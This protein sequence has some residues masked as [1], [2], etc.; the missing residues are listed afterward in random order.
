MKKDLTSGPIFKSLILFSLP[1]ILGNL[2]QQVYNIAD[3]FIVG[4][5]VSA[6]A[7]AAVGSAY[8]LMTFLTSIIIGLCMGSGACFSFYYGQKDFEQ[9]K[10]NISL[11]FV[12][13]GAVTIVIN[14]VVFIFIDGILRLLQVPP[15]LYEMMRA[16]VF[17][18]FFGLFFT[19]LYNFFAYLL[20]GLGNSVVPLYVLG[21]AA[22]LNIVLDIFFV[23]GLQMGVKGAAIATVIAQM[24]AG[25]VLT[26]YA[27]KK[28][29]LLRLNLSGLSLRKKNLA[30]LCRFSFTSSLQQSVMNFGILMIQG[31]VN[32]FGPAVMSAFAAAVKVDSL[33][34]MPA[35]EFGN[36]YSLFISQN[37]GAG[38][39]G[40]IKK[41]TEQ[42]LCISSAFC[43]FIS[44]LVCVF[45]RSLMLVFI[46]ESN[47]DIIRIGM[48][49]LRI[50]GACY[51]GI[52]ILFLLY[53]YFRG[54]N[55]P[56]MSLILTILSLG[57][58]VLL[59][60][61]LAPIPAVG[62]RGIWASIPIGWILA[63]TAGLIT[64]RK[65]RK[66]APGKSPENNNRIK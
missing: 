11:A 30:E 43:L 54:I 47:A 7:L 42:A 33:A 28:E 49:Y 45:A 1:M 14:I 20:R 56:E 23:L 51:I 19:F 60:Y 63:D 5:Y 29:P 66:Q 15:K 22:V 13:T 38:Q 10:K 16:Y 52:G 17:I 65:Y 18:I 62:V 40:R 64:M 32:S 55:R 37:Y 6:D 9:L 35:Q 8:T 24:E 4:Q 12:L 57:T 21:S 58:R 53:G 59:A 36:A 25:I 48:E 46:K 34:Y 61:T 39:S 26:V 2:L 50:E 3:S 44:V 41:G 27:L 31:L